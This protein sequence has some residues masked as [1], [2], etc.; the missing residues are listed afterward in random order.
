MVDGA[1]AVRSVVD[2]TLTI[3]HRVV[4]GQDAAGFLGDIGGLLEDPLEMLV[5]G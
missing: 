5:R 3:D 2:L 4:D 1:L